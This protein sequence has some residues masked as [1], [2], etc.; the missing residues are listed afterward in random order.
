M[1]NTNALH[2]DLYQ[3]TM[4]L[5][6]FQSG[7]ANVPAKCE[8]FTRRLPKNRRFMLVAGLNKVLDYLEQLHF[9]DAQIEALKEIPA[10]RKAFTRDFENYLRNFK[11]TGTVHAVPEGTVLFENEPFLRVEAPLAQVQLVETFILSA[12]NHQTMV[13]SKAARMVLAAEGR[14]LMEFG[15]RRTHC[16]SAVDAARAAYIAG[17]VGTSNV[18]AFYRYDVPVRGTMAHM[19]VMASNNEREAFKQYGKVFENSTYLIDTYDTMQG[20]ENALDVLGDNISAVRIDS[21]DL[22]VMTRKVKEVLKEK[23]RQDIKVILS[24]DL[25]EYALV[26]LSGTE[27]DGA[28]I[29]TKLV[30]SEDSPS[31]GG[32]YK[33]VE[34]EGRPVAKFSTNKVTY[35]GPHQI[36]REI[37]DGKFVNDIIGNEKEDSY[38]FLKKERLLIPVM[39][40]GKRN[41]FERLGDIAARARQ[42]LES[43]PDAAK[44]I[45][46][47][48]Y[49]YPVDVSDNLKT[50]LQRCKEEKK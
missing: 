21:G 37:N 9:T 1:I 20:L 10:L 35:P 24:S 45:V 13:A 43:L 28:G 31:L 48:E 23:G 47:P 25:D 5:S 8:M 41:H 16:E 15:T 46:G 4:M 29:G 19:L 3:I 2:T 14:P 34:I 40:G 11:F 27:Y 33:L 18:E 50:L 49:H 42:Q 6:Y 26:E 32:V 12:I 38:D 44:T 17:F 30:T 22:V 36:Y 39:A 7:K